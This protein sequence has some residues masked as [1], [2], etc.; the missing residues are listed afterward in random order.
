VSLTLDHCVGFV[1]DRL[2]TGGNACAH[3]AARAYAGTT[4]RATTD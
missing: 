2:F 3:F 1:D 4:H